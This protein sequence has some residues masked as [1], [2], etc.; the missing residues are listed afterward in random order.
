[1]PTNH[2]IFAGN[3]RADV[4]EWLEQVNPSKNHNSAGQAHESETGQWLL[5]SKEFKNWI[6]LSDA[7]RARFFWLH[8]I[9]GAGKT[10]MAYTM[11]Q[12]VRARAKT[13][14]SIGYAYY[15]C[16]HGRNKDEAI[17]FL[18]W[19]ICQFCREADFIPVILNELFHEGLEP[20][21]PD[22][23]DCLEAVLTQ[24]RVA[25]IVLDAVDESSPRK[26]LLNI[27]CNLGS[28]QRFAKIRLAVTSREYQDVEAAFGPRSVS[29]S[30]DNK[31]VQEDIKKYV[32]SAL[33][34]PQYEGWGR[35]LRDKV[36][37]TVP[38]MAQGM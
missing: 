16:F 30:M 23:L 3:Q 35:K 22:L 8:G 10:V 5:R 14:K 13:D 17:P 33:R 12:Q 19:I 21:I 28:H 24:F 32:A 4:Y 26:D 34:E 25:Y 31:G 7:A 11:I 29:V 15:Y 1:M 18:R 6:D 9:P 20:S 37:D 36:A 2:P 38:A 27:L